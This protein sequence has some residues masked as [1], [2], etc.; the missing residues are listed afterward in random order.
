MSCLLRFVCNDLDIT[1][2]HPTA[3]SRNEVVARTVEET[4]NSTSW[5]DVTGRKYVYKMA[6]GGL[7]K[8]QY[9]E[10]QELYL[11]H[12]DTETPI[13]F[14]FGRFDSANGVLCNMTLGET[15]PKGIQD[16][17]YVEFDLELTEIKKR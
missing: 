6:W 10:I 1:I 15:K 2:E 7:P 9:E 11:E 5:S 14:Y 13:T 8:S 16:D 17:Y 12:L 4:L 3:Y